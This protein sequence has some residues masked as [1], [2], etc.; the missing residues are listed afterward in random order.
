MGGVK[1]S[2]LVADNTWLGLQVNSSGTNEAVSLQC[3]PVYSFHPVSETFQKQFIPQAGGMAILDYAAYFFF[4]SALK[5]LKPLGN[6]FVAASGEYRIA[7]RIIALD[8][9][10]ITYFIPPD[11]TLGFFFNVKPVTITSIC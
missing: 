11:Y 6:V 8:T 9:L 7:F 2:Q 3:D 5:L 10:A 1:K 4:L